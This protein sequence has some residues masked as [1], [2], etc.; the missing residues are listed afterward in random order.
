MMDNKS[1]AEMLNN[2]LKNE[3]K[4]FN[5]YLYHSTSIKGL[6]R[7]EY[8]E[9]FLE[10][11]KSELEH[12]RE[13][14]KLIM[15]LGGKPC[16]ETLAHPSFFKASEAVEYAY[17]MELE[18]V[19]SYFSQVEMLDSQQKTIETKQVILFLEDQLKQSKEDADKWRI[20]LEGIS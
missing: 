6:L 18:V 17:K 14:S 13:F 3:R 20:I 12:I 8:E 16:V 10:E 2:N 7:K 5:F 1:L 19:E 9:I 15:G 11:A 4:H